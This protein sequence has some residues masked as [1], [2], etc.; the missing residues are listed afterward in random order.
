MTTYFNGFVYH[1]RLWKHSIIIYVITLRDIRATVKTLGRTS[2]GFRVPVLRTTRIRRCAPILPPTRVEAIVVI[3]EVLNRKRK[4][5]VGFVD[6]KTSRTRRVTV[7]HWCPARFQQSFNS[8]SL[9]AP[10]LYVRVCK[11]FSPTAVSHCWR[12]FGKRQN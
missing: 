6:K 9:F 12:S 2:S 8:P 5:R 4:I 10:F 3:F 11:I 7:L 1:E